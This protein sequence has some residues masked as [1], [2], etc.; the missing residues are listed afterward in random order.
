DPH[1]RQV[2]ALRQRLE[3]HHVGEIIAR[4]LQDT[5]RLAGGVDLRVGLVP[6]QQEAGATADVGGGGE[7]R[8]GGEEHLRV[9]GGRRLERGQGGGGV[10]GGG[11]LGGGRRLAHLGVGGV[12]ASRV[13]GVERV[14]PQDGGPAG[15]GRPD[16]ARRDRTEAEAFA[17][18]V[19]HQH[20]GVGVEREGE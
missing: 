7:I 6:E 14:R 20:L 3:E 5:G 19:E 15:A 1:A 18:A 11:V 10:G 17:R 16:A 12:C 13:G 9:H 2:R 8:E 4:R